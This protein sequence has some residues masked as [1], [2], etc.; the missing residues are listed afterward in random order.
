MLKIIQEPILTWLQNFYLNDIQEYAKKFPTIILDSDIPRYDVFGKI[1]FV[2]KLLK[3][4]TKG[5]PCWSLRFYY[6]DTKYEN[7]VQKDIDLN[8]DVWG[9]KEW[10]GIGKKYDCV[11]DAC[12]PLYLSVILESFK[13]WIEGTPFTEI[14]DIN[15]LRAEL[16]LKNPLLCWL[17]EYFLQ[18]CEWDDDGYG[19][20][21][22]GSSLMS[23]A[24]GWIMVMS[25]EELDID[26]KIFNKVLIQ[27][28]GGVVECY[29]LESK[30]IIRA[31]H[32][33]L[34]TGLNIFKDWVE[35]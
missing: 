6:K 23:V 9:S 35:S 13:R 17:E 34:I 20:T 16:K 27:E 1:E 31:H 33:G 14:E 25:L 11:N 26:D 7:N 24:N 15:H 4:A 10:L 19:Y 3:I 28:E 5:N 30:F 29:K 22:L 2:P 8:Q 32:R 12:S 18:C 21:Y